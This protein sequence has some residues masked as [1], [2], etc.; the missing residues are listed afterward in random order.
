MLRL[1]YCD[2]RNV[3]NAGLLLPRWGTFT[4]MKDRRTF[5]VKC[6]FPSCSCQTKSKQTGRYFVSELLFLLQTQFFCFMCQ[7][8]GCKESS[9]ET[10]R[11]QSSSACVWWHPNK[12][13]ARRPLSDRRWRRRSLLFGIRLFSLESTERV[14]P[15]AAWCCNWWHFQHERRE[16]N[17]FCQE[18]TASFLSITPA[19]AFL[20]SLCGNCSLF[21]FSFLFF[22]RS[23]RSHCLH[24]F[25]SS[26]TLLSCLAHFCLRRYDKSN[27]T[28]A[29]EHRLYTGFRLS[30]TA[31]LTAF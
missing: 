9:V 27:A 14:R 28:K 2:F 5:R 30:P 10:R 31:P 24:V 1:L 25:V 26:Q 18:H 3:L 12:H 17:R 11:W 19:L 20:L 29:S 15:P 7:K 16:E 8:S 6:V 21:S 4:D 13:P 22:R 23:T